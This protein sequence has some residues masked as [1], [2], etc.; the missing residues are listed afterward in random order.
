MLKM[1]LLCS[2]ALALAA[3]DRT[4]D[5]QGGTVDNTTNVIVDDRPCE[6]NDT[7]KTCYWE[8]GSPK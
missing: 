2:T 8:D 5:V 3:C 7:R 6:P 4:S 1:L